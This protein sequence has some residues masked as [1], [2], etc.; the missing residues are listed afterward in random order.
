M[1]DSHIYLNSK[2]L[3][4]RNNLVGLMEIVINLRCDG[5]FVGVYG[6]FQQFR[7]RL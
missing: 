4:K 1:R 5:F 6:I 7:L 3:L 2:I